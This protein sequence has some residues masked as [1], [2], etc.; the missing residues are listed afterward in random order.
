MR[1]SPLAATS[2]CVAR[3]ADPGPIDDAEA[4]LANVAVT[5]T[6]ERLDLGA[7]SW[8]HNHPDKSPRPA[9]ALAS[10]LP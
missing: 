7:L 4:R 10:P 8:I 3:G 5:R 1:V 2:S 6:R 9:P